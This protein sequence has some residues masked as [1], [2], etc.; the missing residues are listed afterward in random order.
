MSTK[1][2]LNNAALQSDSIINAYLA[3][4]R[5]YFASTERLTLLALETAHGSFED[6][7]AA[8]RLTVAMGDSATPKVWQAAIGQ[9][10][11]E[12][13]RAFTH[14]TYEILAD[15]QAQVLQVLGSQLAFPAMRFPLSE[16]WTSAFERFSR[17]M[18]DFSA[19]SATNVAA[20]TKNI[21]EIAAKADLLAKK[22]A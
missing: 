14:S 22:A 12:R 15:A 18:R 20:A 6:S 19:M 21:S 11:V 4:S 1:S 16:D 13:V 7:V 5:I 8:T 9:P 10:A 2:Q 3:L 17:G